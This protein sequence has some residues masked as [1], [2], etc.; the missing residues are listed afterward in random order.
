VAFL[1]GC[2]KINSY[3]E[4]WITTIRAG[5]VEMKFCFYESIGLTRADLIIQR[6]QEY[7]CNMNL[8]VL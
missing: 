7:N 5:N 3:D 1:S 8:L 6:V 4:C 2:K